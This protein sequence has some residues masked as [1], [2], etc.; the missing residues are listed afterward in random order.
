MNDLGGGGFL[1][2]CLPLCG[3]VVHVGGGFVM[4]WLVYEASFLF[5][6]RTFCLRR[7]GLSRSSVVFGRFSR[8]PCDVS[9]CT[10]ALL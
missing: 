3:A 1:T 5:A 6:E 4:L 9:P 8:F 10:I 7:L 2:I